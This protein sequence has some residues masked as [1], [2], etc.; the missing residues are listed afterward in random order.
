MID[1]LM[2][3]ICLS[4]AVVVVGGIAAYCKR[5]YDNYEE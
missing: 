1:T 5:V 3:I 2:T 4:Y